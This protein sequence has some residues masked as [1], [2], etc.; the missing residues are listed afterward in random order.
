VAFGVYVHIPFCAHRCDYCDFATWTDRAHLVG[1]YVDACVAD[2]ERRFGAGAVPPADTVFFGG[3]TP[4]LVPP[5]QLARILHAIPRTPG[6]E[7]TVECNPDSVTAE[8]FRVLADAGVDR[9]SIGVQAM[10]PHVLASLGRTHDPENV[11]RAVDGARAAG[12]QRI[13]LD[14]IYGAPGESVQDWAHTMDDALAL[15]PTHVSAYALT[16]EPG[17][18]L[19]IGVAAGERP[20]PD[21]DDQ[22]VKYELADERL[23]AAGFEWYEISNWARPGEECRHN[24]LYW[25]GDD[26]LAIGCAAHG[27][28]GPRRWWNVR[29]PDRY[30]D[31]VES[32]ASTEAGSEELDPA[33]RAGEALSL[34]LRTRAGVEAGALDPVALPAMVDAGLV[35]VADDRATLTRSGRLLASEVTLRVVPAASAG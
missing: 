1:R 14:L 23:A 29:T 18:P 22:A 12:I 7:V 34:A 24:E 6:A 2:I 11:V 13:S 8:G 16:V 9:V 21:D 19:G 26:Y 15:A 25:S 35:Q 3:G 5:A 4:T 20:A 33:G 30:I 27:K 17:T 28:T 10:V 32:G 31:A